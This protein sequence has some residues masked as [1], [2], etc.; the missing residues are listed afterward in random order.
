MTGPAGV[1]PKVVAPAA[2]G[3][4]VDEPVPFGTV[5]S[6]DPATKPLAPD[7]LFGGSPGR[8]L[9][10]GPAGVTA[11]AELRTGPVRSPAAAALA[12]R[13][14]DA[15]VAHPVPAAAGPSDVTIVVPVRDRLVELGECLA[16]LGRS[17]PVV[18]VDDGSVDPAA[19]AAVAARRGAS[20]VRRAIAGGPAA[21][22]NA[23]LR[24][25]ASELVAFVDSDC[26]A[27]PDWVDRLVGHFADPLVAAVAPRIVPLGVSTIGSPLDLGDRP[28]PVAPGTRLPYVPTAALVVRRAALGDGFD[29][30]L[31]YGEDVD[32]VWRLVEA[33][34]RVRYEPAV[35]VGHREPVALADRLRRRFDYGTSAAPLARRHPGRLV[36][37]VVSPSPAATVAALLARRPGVATASFAVGTARLAGRF[38]RFGATWPDV[39]G[40]SATGVTQTWLGAGRFA[41]QF[42][43][44]VL[45]GLLVAPG[46]HTARVRHGRR[47]AVLSLVLGPVLA[48]WRQ[49]RRRAGIIGPGPGPLRYGAELLADQAAYGAGV[50]AGC[51]RERSVEPL[52]PS[53]PGGDVS[54]RR[55]RDRSAGP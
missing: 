42:A 40:A 39:I 20:S 36:H 4:S 13:L 48:G 1:S 55:G 47:L 7:V 32:F 2:L 44:P 38:R 23:A 29:E 45:A 24:L 51:W 11:L 17:Y 3:R 5:V 21:A 52:V 27:P 18:V 9:R 43:W 53:R 15:G 19:I 12:R 50:Y 6:I 41:G 33:G 37:L 26:V 10:L 30:A 54:R 34:W 22:R 25:V 31:R 46:G 14:T 16:F 8:L 49:A 35:E 28:G